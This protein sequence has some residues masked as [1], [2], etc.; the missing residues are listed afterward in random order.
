MQSSEAYRGTKLK[1]PM[2][3]RRA[4]A[5]LRTNSYERVFLKVLA[6]A[7][8]S[9]LGFP[10][11]AAGQARQ[12]PHAFNNGVAYTFER[13]FASREVNDAHDHG[14]ISLAVYIWRPLVQNRHEV[15]LFSHGSLG[16]ISGDPHEPFQY[17]PQNLIEFLVKRG[18]TVVEP[19]RR[20]LGESTGTFVE[21]CAFAAAKCSL[22]EYRA[23]AE[24]GLLEAI[25]D[26]NAVID[27]VIEG[28]E[29]P[30]RS[31][32]LFVGISRGGLLS[33][34]MAAERPDLCKAVINFVGGW[35]SITDA[36]PPEEN[37]ERVT[38]ADKWFR[39]IGAQARAP[40]IW[41]YASRDSAYSERTTRGFFAKFQEGGG[42]GEY[43]FVADHSLSSGHQVAS[44]PKLWD[45]K[46]D[47]FLSGLR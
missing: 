28:K 45:A 40:T 47:A 44:D 13:K 18:Y 16:G 35:L 38:L 1:L 22:A 41:I 5:V 33:L 29:V 30:Q 8:A 36:W 21:E 32:L 25:R 27:Q 24:P 19:T 2:R 42:T 23:L 7:G 17:M 43:V 14:L 10:G 46:V 6:I 39:S 26:S 20:G 34:R 3:V 11:T 15:A 12:D 31:K 4:T 37:S 9:V